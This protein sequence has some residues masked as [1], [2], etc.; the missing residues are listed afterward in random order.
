MEQDELDTLLEKL[1]THKLAVSGKDPLNTETSAKINFNSGIE[2]A[3]G[4]IVSH[5]ISKGIADSK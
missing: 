2:T 5:F 1:E 3:K 4:I